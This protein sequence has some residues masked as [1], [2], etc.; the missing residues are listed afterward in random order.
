MI[1]ETTVKNPITKSGIPIADYAIN[2]YIGCTFGCK[3]CFAQFIGA[4]KY[5]KGQWGK[6]IWIRKNIPQVLPKSLSKI[7]RGRFF[8]SSACDPYQHIE[9]KTKLTREILRILISRWI[10]VFIMTKSTLILRDLDLLK[11]AKDLVVNITI[12]SDREDVR[13][14][15]E[16]GGPSFEERLKTVRK[17]K[18]AGINT[19]VFVGPVLPMNPEKLAYNLK[20]IVDRVHLDPLNYP[21]QVRALYKKLGWESWLYRDKFEQVKE[22]FESIFKKKNIN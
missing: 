22:T 9:K 13:K 11:E 10:P 3:Y 15:L 14:I 21:N 2:P 16:P 20:K 1:Y 6:D 7:S 5:K 19:G 4:F 17:L 8:I 18:E 12:T